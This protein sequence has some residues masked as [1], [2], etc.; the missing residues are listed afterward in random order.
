MQQ[1]P[2]R[3]PRQVVHL[4]PAM[5]QDVGAPGKRGRGQS[6]SMDKAGRCQIFFWRPWLFARSWR[7]A[8]FFSGTPRLFANL[9]QSTDFYSS[10]SHLSEEVFLH[11]SALELVGVAAW[12]SLHLTRIEAAARRRQRRGAGMGTSKGAAR[13]WRRGSAKGVHPSERAGPTTPGKAI[14]SMS[15][16]QARS[17]RPR[18]PGESPRGSGAGR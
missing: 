2:L 1:S 18:L 6:G 13:A 17:W 14:L 15:P 10:R 8:A 12:I 4:R 9:S 5:E 7:C 16:R 3:T 11:G